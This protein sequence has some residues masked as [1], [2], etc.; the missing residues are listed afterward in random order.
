MIESKRRIPSYLNLKSYA[1]EKLR[2]LDIIYDRGFYTW[3][4]TMMGSF[5]YRE[6]YAPPKSAYEH[7]MKAGIEP[8]WDIV[9]VGGILKLGN[10]SEKVVKYGYWF[11][12]GCD[13]LAKYCYDIYI[14][15][16]KKTPFY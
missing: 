3:N 4:D 8:I 2:E 14:S 16:N 10:N 15:E 9:Y 11:P 6:Y 13:E 12:K 7:L 1:Q 5:T